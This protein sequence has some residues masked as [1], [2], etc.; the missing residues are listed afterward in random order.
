MTI[1]TVLVILSSIFTVVSAIPYII[2]IVR[3][4]TKPRVVSWLTW[5]VLTGIAGIASY[6]D[7]QYPAAI[8][9]FFATI[10][11]LLIVILGWKHGDRKIERFDIVCLVGALIGIILWQVF[12]SPAIA[13]VAAVSIDLIGGLPT[14][15]HSWQKPH[16]ETWLTFFLAFLGGLCTVLAISEW[17]VTSVAYPLYIVVINLA[18]VMVL[19]VRRKYGVV[20]EPKEL[21]KL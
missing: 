4:T 9:M 1:T 15:V 17:T 2:E 3:G 14:I 20:G 13:V 16:E 5:S 11:T 7:G 18:F 10:E 21:R 6:V 8:L 19:F 12:N